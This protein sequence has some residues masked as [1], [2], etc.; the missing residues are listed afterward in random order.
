MSFLWQFNAQEEMPYPRSSAGGNGC[1]KQ[2]PAAYD[3]VTETP[4]TSSGRSVR[5]EGVLLPNHPILAPSVTSPVYQSVVNP[6]PAATQ[7]GAP[8][9][10]KPSIPGPQNS[11]DV[12][13]ERTIIQSPLGSQYRRRTL[14]LFSTI[15]RQFSSSGKASSAGL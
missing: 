5:P 3:P 15:K 6:T 8:I 10:C 9:Q 2:L 7:T 14:S 13:P 12:N 11:D 1:H 4:E